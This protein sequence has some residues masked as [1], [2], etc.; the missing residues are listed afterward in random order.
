MY[1]INGTWNPRENIS[2]RAWDGYWDKQAAA[3]GGI[4]LVELTGEAQLNAIQAGDVELSVIDDAS[5]ADTLASSGFTVDVSPSNQYGLFILNE[6]KPPL[7]NL[8]VRQAI[9][10]AI[11]R[12]AI[13]QALTF[14][15]SDAAYQFFP[16]SSPIYDSN[17]DSLYPHD[18]DKAK[19]L[20]ADA[21]MADGFQLNAAVGNAS[22]LYIQM[23][24]LIA[25]QLKEVGIDMKLNLIDQASANNEIVRNGTYPAAPYGGQTLANTGKQFNDYFMPGG[26]NNAG[27]NEAPGLA[28]ILTQAGA[29]TDASTRNELFRQANKIVTDQVQNGVPIY[30]QPSV[31][32]S[33]PYVGGVVDGQLRCL[34]DFRGV[35]ITQGQS[36]VGS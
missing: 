11:D 9:S 30:F 3:L 24:E 13:A 34:F 17:L 8:K 21:G 19:Q 2:V 7:D 16:P 25:G 26:V 12:Q 31:T 5:S 29:S 28:D 6:T 4:D 32:V 35:Y 33:K 22:P 20:L 23:G 14:G 1:K 18:V 36:P 15:K 27:N 10:Y